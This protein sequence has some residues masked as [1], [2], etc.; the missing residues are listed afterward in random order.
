MTERELHLFVDNSNVLLEGR[1]FAEMKRT[2]RPRLGPY[3][4]DSYEIDWGK[5][6]GRRSARRS[7]AARVVVPG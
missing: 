7:A 2:S 3:L 5:Y 1:R 4:D 6:L